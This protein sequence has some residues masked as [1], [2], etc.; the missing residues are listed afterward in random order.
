[1]AFA[2]TI[3]LSA[4]MVLAATMALTALM[5]VA[6][7]LGAMMTLAKCSLDPEPDREP[8]PEPDPD[9]GPGSEPEPKFDSQKGEK[10]RISYIVRYSNCNCKVERKVGGE[11]REGGGKLVFLGFYFGFGN[12]ISFT[13]RTR[14][15]KTKS[16][17]TSE[18]K[19]GEEVRQG[20]EDRYREIEGFRF[21]FELEL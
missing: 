12:Q 9:S 21:E 19:R 8:E 13:T 2:A 11:G 7:F 17:C 5:A 14:T 6:L 20:A 1:M 3:A 16:F 18:G 10:W 4:T 15:P